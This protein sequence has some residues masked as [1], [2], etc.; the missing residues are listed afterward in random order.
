MAYPDVQVDVEVVHRQ[1]AY[2]LVEES[3]NADLLL[4]SRPAHGGFVHYLGATARAVIRDGA[5][6]IEVVPPVDE[7]LQ[8]EH[9]DTADVRVP[10]VRS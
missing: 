10:S 4:I 6:P 5:C 9:L 2:A 1:A 3:R 8:V 7:T